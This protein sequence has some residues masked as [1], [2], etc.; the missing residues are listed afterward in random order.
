MRL[1]WIA[2]FIVTGKRNCWVGLDDR[3]KANFL[4]VENEP[5]GGV[6]FVRMFLRDPSSYLREFRRKPRSTPNG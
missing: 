4:L 3:F 5:T 2:P 1:L 6:P